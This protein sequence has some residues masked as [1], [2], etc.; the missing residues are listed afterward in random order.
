MWDGAHPTIFI[1]ALDHLDAHPRLE[2]LVTRSSWRSSKT[3]SAVTRPSWRS[4]HDFQK[5]Q[6][7]PWR[8]SHDSRKVTGP[9]RRSS[10]A[11][12]GGARRSQHS[13]QLLR[14]LPK[15]K[16]GSSIDARSGQRRYRPS[17]PA[18]IPGKGKPR[19]AKPPRGS[20]RSWLKSGELLESIRRQKPSG[21][22][23]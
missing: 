12:C 16:R 4:S 14:E 13:S 21:K 7:H 2:D 17:S 3:A 23:R 22:P 18:P 10:H 19:A 5:V 15:A 11:C 8:S 1:S 9:S 20:P 6:E